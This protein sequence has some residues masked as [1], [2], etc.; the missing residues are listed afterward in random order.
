[1]MINKLDFH[2]MFRHKFM[3]SLLNHFRKMKAYISKYRQ[4]NKTI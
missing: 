4:M 3:E 2:P 1:M